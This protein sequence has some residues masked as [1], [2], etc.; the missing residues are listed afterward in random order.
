MSF[1]EDAADEARA[2]VA[3]FVSSVRDRADKMRGLTLEGIWDETCEYVRENPGK[4]I[5]A[6]VAVGVILGSL[7]RRNK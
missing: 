3:E 4:A 6:S 7:L 5:L 1:P 2:K